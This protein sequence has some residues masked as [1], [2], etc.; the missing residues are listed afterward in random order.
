MS[1][2]CGC[3]HLTRKGTV[4]VEEICTNCPVK[5][6]PS[7]PCIFWHY[8]VWQSLLPATN[9]DSSSTGDL[10]GTSFSA[11]FAQVTHLGLPWPPSTPATLSTA[12]I[13]FIPLCQLIFLL[14]FN[15]YLLLPQH[16]HLVGRTPGPS[17]VTTI[18][19]QKIFCDE[20]IKEWKK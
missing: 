20:D 15:A 13:P 7:V 16:F 14:V 9:L 12:S 1:S 3:S 19:G 5:K 10:P 4:W 11:P 17:S 18:G 8:F 2:R 6:R